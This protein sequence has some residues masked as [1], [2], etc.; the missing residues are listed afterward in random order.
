MIQR[1]NFRC[2]SLWWRTSHTS[3][4]VQDF[5]LLFALASIVK[6]IV[7][8][9]GSTLRRKGC[10]SEIAVF[11]ISH[12]QRYT[13]LIVHVLTIIGIRIPNTIPVCSHL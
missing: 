7:V 3:H 12:N 1:H 5:A 11:F 13:A 10:V 4:R 8:H 6:F 2:C 9:G